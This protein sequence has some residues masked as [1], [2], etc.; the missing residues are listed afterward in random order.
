MDAIYWVLT[1]ACHRRCAHC[2]DDRFRPYV[3]DDLR[4]VVGEGQAAYLKIIENLPDDFSVADPSRPQADGTPGRRRGRL[5]MAGGELLIDGVR[6]ELFYPALDALA[7]RWTDGRGPALAVQTTGDVLTPAHLEAMLARGVTSFAI[8]SVDDYHVG[9]EGEKRYAFM[10]R[11]RALMDRFG[12]VER[13]LGVA[14]DER[15]KSPR[16]AAKAGGPSFLFMGAQEDLW[17]GEVWPR[18]R[19]WENGLSKAGY[20]TNFCARWSGG[21]N[22]L[23]YGEIGS[24]VAVEPDGS[25]YPCCLKTKAPL[26]SLAEERLTDILDSLKDHPAMAAINAGDPE[27]MGTA[28]GWSRGDFAA[29]S[30][31]TDPTG[32]PYANLCIGCDVFFERVLGADLRRIRAERLAR[33][34]GPAF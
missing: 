25:V 19:A 12:I 1:W 20:D 9:M 16:G 2:Y 26:G 24:E 17:I 8:T 11:I 4:R 34:A 21:Q 15:L 29:A 10:D 5:V 22:F 6:D 27:A 3:R 32:R 14:K 28:F 13:D 30:H 7:R 33:R 18:G 23:N 31:T